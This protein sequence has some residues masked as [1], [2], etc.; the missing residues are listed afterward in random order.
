MAVPGIGD[1]VSRRR[2]FVRFGVVFLVAMVLTPLLGR[3][4]A[5]AFDDWGLGCQDKR[6]ASIAFSGDAAWSTTIT[7]GPNY[8]QT[9]E[10]AV[11]SGY[12]SWTGTVIRTPWGSSALGSGGSTFTMDFVATSASWAAQTRCW[13]SKIVF[14]SGYGDYLQD[15]SYVLSG[16][17]THEWG[18]V[19]GL[20]HAGRFD[21]FGGGEP[22]MSTCWNDFDEQR[23]IAQDDSAGIQFQVN[24]SGS[25][26]AATANPS[27]ENG[28]RWWGLQGVGSHQIRSGGV[29]GTPKY[30]RIYGSKSYTAIFSTTRL[31]DYAED[32]NQAGAW[33]KA[34]AN[35]KKITS[36]STG[37]VLVQAK[38]RHVDFSGSNLKDTDCQ[39]RYDI[40]DPTQ[41]TGPWQVI[42][43]YCY[44]T[45]SWDY[46]TTAVG[47]VQE[48]DSR[49]WRSEGIDVRVVVYNRMKLNGEYLG[50]DL[51]RTRMLVVP[52]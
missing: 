47:V 31:T 36:A 26:G 18:H 6:Y 13:D 27:F 32:G 14:N 48:Y 24:K 16:L 50:V 40:N 22:S 19:W 1:F 11:R 51:D 28:T 7:G 35:Y 5:A 46:C 20:G 4:P 15:G 2:S 43:K 49:G 39:I 44:P 25:Y 9:F 12:N 29:D 17:S 52:S 41:Y 37:Y 42:S 45:S 33:V 10:A 3:P 21:S 34:R 8:G 23:A 38:W 30:L